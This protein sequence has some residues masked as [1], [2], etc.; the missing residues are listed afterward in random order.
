MRVKMTQGSALFFV[1]VSLCA[2]ISAVSGAITLPK[3]ATVLHF[4]KINSTCKYV[5]PF[6]KHQVKLVWDRD[7]SITAALLRLLYSDCFVTVCEPICNGKRRSARHIQGD[8]GY[9]QMNIVVNE[10]IFL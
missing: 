2:C 10:S 1:A 5:E 6:V 8:A 4:Y 9:Q 7:K 3:G